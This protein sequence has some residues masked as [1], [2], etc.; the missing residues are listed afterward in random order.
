MKKIS[1]GVALIKFS[2]PKVLSMLLTQMIEVVSLNVSPYSNGWNS[3]EPTVSPKGEQRDLN[4][5]EKNAVGVGFFSGKCFRGSGCIEDVIETL[6]AHVFVCPS[7]IQASINLVGVLPDS[8]TYRDIHELSA[9]VWNSTYQRWRIAA[10]HHRTI[11]KVNSCKLLMV[12]QKG[13]Y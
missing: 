12:L 3:R 4:H 7:N 10:G 13:R 1:I 2:T 9:S 8:G 11:L 5:N 6:R